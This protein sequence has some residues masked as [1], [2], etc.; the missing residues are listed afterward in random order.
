MALGPLD[1]IRPRLATPDDRETVLAFHRSLDADFLPPLSTRSPLERLAADAVGAPGHGCLLACEAGGAVRAMAVFRPYA[2]RAATAEL[3]FLGVEAA[4]RGRGLA[5]VLRELVFVELGSR[6]FRTIRTRTHSRNLAMIR[7]NASQGFR[8]VEVVPDDRGP[9]ID[10]LWY[11][12]AVD[13]SAG[14]GVPA[15]G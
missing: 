7:L 11:E 15:A 2:G 1:A 14:G 10:S 3:V 12:R 5:R 4:W 8:L 6:G 9:G 13:L